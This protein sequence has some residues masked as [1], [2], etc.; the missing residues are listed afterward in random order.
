MDIDCPKCQAVI[1]V[2]SEDLPELACDSCDYTCPECSAVF[3]IGWYAEAEVRSVE[4][5]KPAIK[6][7][8]FSQLGIESLPDGK[9][10]CDCVGWCFAKDCSGRCYIYSVQPNYSAL[11]HR[12]AVANPSS[13]YINLGCSTDHSELVTSTPY[14]DCLFLITGVE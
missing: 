6:S 2:Y 11:T 12:W 13:E 14:Q 9:L 7:S 5:E 4:P 3:Q 8:T 10:L 1:E